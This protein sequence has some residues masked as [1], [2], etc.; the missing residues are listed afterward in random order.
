MHPVGPYPVVRQWAWIDETVEGCS[1]ALR[2]R[3]HP[4]A[5]LK[6]DAAAA[7]PAHFL[8]GSLNDGAVLIVFFVTGVARALAYLWTEQ[9]QC[10][11][12]PQ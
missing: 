7:P 6:H 12:L 9:E 5:N 3:T 1:L 10:V 4:R 11:G 2:P 8:L